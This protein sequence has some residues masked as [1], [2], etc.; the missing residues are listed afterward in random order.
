MKPMVRLVL[1]GMLGAWCG[2]EA[3]AQAGMENA[4]GQ[5]RSGFA[6]SDYAYDC[7][8][9]GPFNDSGGDPAL[10]YWIFEPAGGTKLRPS[11][12]PYVIWVHGYKLDIPDDYYRDLL[13]H[14]CRKGFPVIAPQYDSAVTPVAK[15]FP[16]L[17][18]VVSR[19]GAAFRR[20]NADPATYV[21]P[22]ADGAGGFVTVAAGHSVGAD[23][24]FAMADASYKPGSELSRI[25][26]FV[27][28][29]PVL[30]R[31]DTYPTGTN[32]PPDEKFAI[33]IGGTDRN[34]GRKCMAATLW[35]SASHVS[36]ANKP[37]F[38][39]NDVRPG[40]PSLSGNHFWP[41][42]APAGPHPA[43]SQ[44][45]VLDFAIS[46]RYITAAA[47]CAAGD[48]SGCTVL[49]QTSVPIDGAAASAPTYVPDPVGYLQSDGP[50]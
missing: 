8:E 31:R 25:R 12:A 27:A 9:L 2:G 37:F 36:A 18:A 19:R 1:L 23:E 15:F 11:A 49:V 5:P 24:V 34:A 13:M 32:L 10:N 50:C 44:T 21:K 41:L 17:L 16:N 46:F 22:L 47:A 28:L 45:N 4:T 40:D 38:V 30:A 3:M 26:Y 35:R 14:V 33:F 7:R 39:V 48:P 43:I 29:E 42:A 20:I 6:G